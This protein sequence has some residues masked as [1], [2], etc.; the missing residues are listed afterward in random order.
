MVR[1]SIDCCHE[2]PK[3]AECTVRSENNQNLGIICRHGQH[4][5]SVINDILDLSK[6]EAGRMSVETQPCS[7]VAMVAN[8]ASI[9]RVRADEHRIELAAEFAGQLPETVQTDEGRLRQALMNLVGSAIKFTEQGGVRIVTSFLSAWHDGQPAL[10]IQVIDTGIGIS[11]DQIPGLFD[12]FIQADTS[13]TRQYG[14]TGLGLAI[15]HRIAE[16]LGGDLSVESTPGKGSTFTLTVPTGS[17]ESVRMLKNPMAETVQSQPAFTSDDRGQ[18]GADLGGVRVLL[19]MASHSGLE[20][21]RNAH[22]FCRLHPPLCRR[23]LLRR[24][25]D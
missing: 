3:W 10:S 21:L 4:L 6:I 20:R 2:C 7:P 9:M 1:E 18:G 12:P 22:G 14:G 11:E 17:I 23:H 24:L 15:T 13:T 5:L 16:L 8:V 19:V 25:D